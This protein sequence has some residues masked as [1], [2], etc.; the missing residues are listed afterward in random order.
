MRLLSALLL[1]CGLASARAGDQAAAPSIPSRSSQTNA[2]RHPQL[3][4]VITEFHN[5]DSMA[6]EYEL[7]DDGRQQYSVV[8][9]ASNGPNIRTGNGYSP[10]LTET[11]LNAMT[12]AIR[13]LPLTNASPPFDELVLVSFYQGTN[14]ST[15]RYDRRGLPKAMS[16]IYEIRRA[17][18]VRSFTVQ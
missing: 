8:S 12:S 13:E 9:Y 4:L 11:Q 3:I 16:Q 17:R 5:T 10:K 6:H 7:T 15:S 2:A 1:S 14:W 18:W